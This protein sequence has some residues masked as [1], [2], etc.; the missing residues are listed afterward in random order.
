MA[1]G[2]SIVNFFVNNVADEPSVLLKPP[3][4]SN[5]LKMFLKAKGMDLYEDFCL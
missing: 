1:D 5:S 4:L 2:T 3:V